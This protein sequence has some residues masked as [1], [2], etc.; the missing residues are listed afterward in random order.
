MQLCSGDIICKHKLMGKTNIYLFLLYL[1]Q[2]YCWVAP[3]LIDQ[4]FVSLIF[5]F[6]KAL[7]K[8]K[9]TEGLC[10]SLKNLLRAFSTFLQQMFRDQL[11]PSPSAAKILKFTSKK[12][13]KICTFIAWKKR[14]NSFV[15]T[16][17]SLLKWNTAQLLQSLCKAITQVAKW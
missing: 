14:R 13:W 5:H 9:S 11:V 2:R 6:M 8:K 7:F 15:L 12:V 4:G 3:Y 17:L 16:L 10:L 1:H